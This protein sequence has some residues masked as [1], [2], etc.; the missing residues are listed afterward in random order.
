MPLKSCDS[1]F[2]LYANGSKNNTTLA[3]TLKGLNLLFDIQTTIHHIENCT[4]HAVIP[5]VGLYGKLLEDSLGCCS[6]AAK[7]FSFLPEEI[8]IPYICLN[9]FCKLAICSVPVTHAALWT[10]AVQTSSSD[11]ERSVRLAFIILHHS[12]A[13]H[14]THF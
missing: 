8:H 7:V 1:L 5:K 3:N 9:E 14:N 10:E 2:W 13:T 11:L 12:S 4:K 6:A